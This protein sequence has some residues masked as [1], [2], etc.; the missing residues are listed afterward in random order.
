[1]FLTDGRLG[2]RREG[3]VFRLQ[4]NFLDWIFFHSY[5]LKT[6]S[7]ALKDCQVKLKMLVAQSCPTLC[8]PMGCSTPGFSILGILQ[9]RILE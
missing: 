3:V 8:D 9:V 4:W 6:I 2:N 7:E 5:A 1:M